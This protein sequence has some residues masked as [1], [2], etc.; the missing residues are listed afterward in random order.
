VETTPPA[1]SEP[2]HT[3]DDAPLPPRY[4]VDECIAA[5][6]DDAKVHAEAFELELGFL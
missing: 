5:H 1:P 2:D 6:K 3:L 4:D